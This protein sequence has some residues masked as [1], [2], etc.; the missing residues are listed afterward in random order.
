MRSPN[1]FQAQQGYFTFAQNTDTVNYLELAYAQAVS[2]KNTQTINQYAVAVDSETKKLI[3]DEHKSVFDYIV[4]ICDPDAHAMS[5]E[6]QA[7]H[8]TPFKETI[9]LESDILFTT[10]VDHWWTGMRLQ[11]VCFTTKIR[12]YEGVVS[13]ARAYRKLFDENN[14]PDIY[15][16]MY[17]FRFGRTSMELFQLAE[18]VYSNWGLFR[19]DL[20]K[21][22]R[23][24]RPS[25]DIV[26]AIAAKILGQELCTNPALDYPSFVHMKGAVNGLALSANWQDVYHAELYNNNLMINFTRQ[27]WPVHYYQKDFINDRIRTELIS[28]F[29]EL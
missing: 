10:N 13:N 28:S 11:E 17:Y 14:L 4:D 26:F 2:I 1:S 7:W 20:L 18:A 29:S 16:G 15:T 21:N 24:D 5:N 8:L 3:T 23:E 25:T 19:D 9:K 27:T 6:W 22:C 12:N